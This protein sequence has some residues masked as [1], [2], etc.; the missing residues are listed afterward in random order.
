MEQK[1]NLS[2][3]D[4]ESFYAHQTSIN[5]NPTMVFFDFKNI[6]PRIDERSRESQTFA[7][8]HNVIMM[9]PYQSLLLR[10]ALDKAVKDYEKRFGKIEEPKALK[11]V[12]KKKKKQAKE[13]IPNYF[14]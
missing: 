3:N 2:I 1:I 14:G 7:L 12:D 5:F 9:D 8:K 11:K 10:N 4:G 13:D 6:S